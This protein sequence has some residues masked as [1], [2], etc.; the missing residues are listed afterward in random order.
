MET[1]QDQVAKNWRELIRPRQLEADEGTSTDLYGRFACEPLERGFGVTLGN[2]L[3][4]TLLSALQ[5]SAITSVRIDGIHHEFSSIPGVMED[6]S[7]II[8]NLKEVRL[9]SHVDSILRVVLDFGR[10]IHAVLQ[11]S[12]RAGE[13]SEAEHH[14]NVLRDD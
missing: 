11:R 9:R 4:R 2:A 10:R 5:G 8:L 14:A 12:G 1:I 13:R 3:R 6:V 7:D